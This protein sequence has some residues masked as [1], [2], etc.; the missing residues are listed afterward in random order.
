MKKYLTTVQIKRT[1]SIKSVLIPS[2][3]AVRAPHSATITVKAAPRLQRAK[4]S[5]DLQLTL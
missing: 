1:W 5:A 2:P 4:P 3:E